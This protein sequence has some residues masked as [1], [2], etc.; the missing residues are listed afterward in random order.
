MRRNWTP[1]IVP[2]GHDQ[3]FYLVINNYGKSGAAFSETDRGEAD[4]ETTIKCFCGNHLQPTNQ[5]RLTRRL[6]EDAGG[7]FLQR[8][9]DGPWICKTM[10]SC[11][12]AWHRAPARIRLLA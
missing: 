7:V 3:T 12:P 6:V 5:R 9:L 4:A 11:A 10:M 2:N 1:S 8:V